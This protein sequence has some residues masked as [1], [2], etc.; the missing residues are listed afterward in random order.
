MSQEELTQILTQLRGLVR[1]PPTQ[2]PPAPPQP[3]QWSAPQVTTP[4]VPNAY[5][6]APPSSF[7]AAHP[8]YSV[9]Q[10]KSEPLAPLLPAASVSET[11]IPADQTQLNITNILSSLMKSGLVSA[12][13][14]DPTSSKAG[15]VEPEED[16]KPAAPTAEDLN[17][18]KEAQTDYR[19]RILAEKM[20]ASLVENSVYV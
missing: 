19:K 15:S 8:A 16:A 12:P 6:H 1:P 14:T 17:A 20:E 2:A 5:A 7:P 10:T 11:S 18:I 13:P 3:H 9:P 4:P